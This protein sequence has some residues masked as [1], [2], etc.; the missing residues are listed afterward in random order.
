MIRPRARRGSAMLEF[1]LC[2]IPMIFIWIGI[3]Q[4]A[5][6]MWHYEV[7][8][9]A[10]KTAGTYVAR[11]GSFYIAAGNSAARIQDAANVLGS[12]AIGIPASSISVTWTATPSV[13]STTTLTCV[14]SACKTNTTTWPPTA[15]SFPGSVVTIKTDYVYR[16]SLAMFVPGKGAARF[17]APNLPGWTRQ[18]VLF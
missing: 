15:A 16:S 4:M 6:G 7:M 14:L 9:Y 1:V 3:V 10:V 12:A 13:G 8:Q 18:V 11:H 17:R 5:I 2:G